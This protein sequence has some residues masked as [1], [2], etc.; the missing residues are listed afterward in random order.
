MPAH[1]A[2][3][4]EAL[5]Y[6]MDVRVRAQVLAF[7]EAGHR[8]TVLCPTG[9]GHDLH[10]ERHPQVRVLRF[11]CPPGGRGALGYLRE[12]SLS[13]VRIARLLRRTQRETPI[14][15]LLVCNPP[16]LL[17]ALKWLLPRPRPKVV[18]DY[19]EI[20]PELFE[21]KFG[22]SNGLAGRALR[23]ALRWSER[24]AF[25]GS[26]VVITVSES[27]R[28][29]AEGRGAVTPERVF[30]VG[31][32]PDG[33]RVYPVPPRPELRAGHERLVLWLGAMSKQEGLERLIDAAHELVNVRGHADVGFAI[34]GPGDVGDELRAQIRRRGLDRIVEVHGLVNDDLVRAYMATADVCVGVDARN[35]MN[36]KAAMRKVLEYMAAARPVVQFPL[37]EMRRLCGDST[38]YA[39]NADVRDLARAIDELLD[40]EEG[41]T[42]L[43]ESGR[44]RVQ[45]GMMW[46]Q[47]VPSLLSAVETA[48]AA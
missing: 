38:A 19:R 25:R 17:V 6:P 44:R 12:Y 29:I 1:V 41:R 22:R 11:G 13:I 9:Y 3:M 15:L 46:Q 26:D 35:S 37:T 10:E 45:A 47:Q 33:D 48:L 20:S 28:E 8:V 21:A 30:L 39:A 42:R 18:L 43:A 34:V 24:V 23:R 2:V 5:P 4:V 16:D 27:C 36:D 32:G 40:D 7:V 31:N 14:D